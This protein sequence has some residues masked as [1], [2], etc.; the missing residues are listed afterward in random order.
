MSQLTR[1][2][3][4]MG[5]ACLLAVSATAASAAQQASVEISMKAEKEII[6]VDD[7]GKK[8]TK[9]ISVAVL[10]EHGN[11]STSQIEAAVTLGDEVIYT[12]TYANKSEDAAT[13]VVITNPVPAHMHYENGSA[14]GPNS[15]FEY[16]VDGSHFATADKLTVTVDGRT[17]H[18]Q[19]EDYTHVRWTLAEPLSPGQQGQ[20]SYR[21]VLEYRQRFGSCTGHTRVWR[22]RK[23]AGQQS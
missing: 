7:N 12:I 9:R 15:L 13:N 8:A 21:A 11:K 6:V 18:A 1:K 14:Q 16:S 3:M 4:R 20:L 19:P 23:K 5:L 22:H 2:T 17:R 10:D